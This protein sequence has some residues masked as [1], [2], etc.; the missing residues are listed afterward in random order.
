MKRTHFETLILKYP[1]LSEE[2]GSYALM[3]T[4]EDSKV[5]RLRLS[6]AHPMSSHS[7]RTVTVS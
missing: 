3:F 4:S 1:V 7:S 2:Q 5:N 6:A